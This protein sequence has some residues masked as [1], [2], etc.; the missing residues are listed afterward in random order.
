MHHTP[1][2]ATIAASFVVAFFLGM[3]AN[4]LKFPPIVG[5]LVA[6]I[7]VGPFTP[8]FVADGD[9]A[10]ELAEIGVI[11]LMFG[12]GLH[13]SYKDLFAVRK[14]AIPGAIAQ[15][16]VATLLGMGLAW[17]L[18]WPLAGG[19][20]FGLALSVASTVVLL[21]AL[22]DRQLLD[23]RSGHVA[24]GW[25]IVEDIAMI[26][27]L[28]LLPVVAQ[29][30]PGVAE[31][32]ALSA[33]GDAHAAAEPGG[34]ILLSLALTLGKLVAFTGLIF[35]VGR[36]VIPWAL[37][38]VAGSG[39]RELF[40]LSVL[41]IGIGVAYF[42]AVF[43]DVSFALGAFFAGMV[44]KESELS[45][46]AAENTLPLRD[47]FAV[48]FFVSVG[49]LFNP[50][51]LVEQ[52]LAVLATL[53]IIVIGKSVAAFL[54]VRAFGYPTDTALLISASLA[55]IGEFSFI[56]MSLGIG[57]GLI[58]EAARDLVLAGAILSIMLSPA[59]F[60]FADRLRARRLAREAAQEAAA[61]VDDE[62]D[63]PRHVSEADHT[64]VVGYGRVGRRVA[65][66]LA[67]KG[68]PV[69]VVESDI[70]RVET[71]RL[72]GRTAILG[73]AVRDEVLRAAGVEKAKHLIVAVPNGL[74]SGEVVAHARKLNPSLRIVAR[75]HLDAEVD[76]LNASGADRVIMGEREIARLMLADVAPAPTV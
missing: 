64:I 63:A 56:L 22:E 52:P 37:A 9:L 29:V 51:V 17:F 46:Q 30:L 12:V 50:A 73:N 32:A 10:A 20:V 61:T 34:N 39:S 16:V 57:L 69:V 6:G 8:G 70:E 54:I 62:P 2:L 18:D 44:L 43:F 45:H 65:D 36:R 53:S 31:S 7:I 21:R 47:A 13:F 66:T 27:A 68:L 67:E 48:L 3:I 26:F 42:A 72:A 71:L 38:R 55:Q 74:E 41:A 49:M 24:I 15:I 23:T 75:A 4:R 35:V 59:I 14:I 40:T 1:L 28:V 33:A 76:H 25:L 5:Y 60:L 58:P 11:L 19:I